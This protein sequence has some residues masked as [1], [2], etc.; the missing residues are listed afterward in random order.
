MSPIG[1]ARMV[2]EY[3][4]SCLVP[5]LKT[6]RLHNELGSE[7]AT[8][9][10]EGIE[11]CPDGGKWEY[12]PR[13][14]EI[15]ILWDSAP[16]HLPSNHVQVSA[17]HKYAQDKLGLR[18]VVHTPPYSAWFNPVELL[19]S[20][21]KRYCRKFAPP[22]IPSLLQR[23]REAT[24]Q[25]TASMVAGWF[26]KSG[27][28]IPGEAPREDPLD[29]NA[30]AERCTLPAD[31]VF[32]RREHV[33]CFDEA[34]K[35]RREKKQGHKRWSQYDTMEDEE[36]A[37]LR[38]LSAVKRSAVR[39]KKRAKVGACAPP[40]EGRTRWTGLGDEPEGVQH[41]DYSKLWDTNQYNEVEA[42]VD[43]RVR[44]GKTEFLTKWLG[45]DETYNE[46][47]SED[48]FSAGSTSLIRSWRE[49]NRRLADA[50]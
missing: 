32:E 28:I 17:F 11:S 30:G 50:K 31:A 39:P 15:S 49:R 18:G 6:G 24:A 40:D 29:P 27:Y 4:Y 22:D 3:L 9:I 26:R 13:L 35:L 14:G 34:G 42:I 5:Y 33:A 10:D 7:C 12:K 16:S 37:N 47:L 36:A 1:D 43:E 20:Y 23:I 8:S 45:Y 44:N 25:I 21:V 19:F 2:S 41:A 46:W 38:N 48:K